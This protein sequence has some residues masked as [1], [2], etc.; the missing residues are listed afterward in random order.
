MRVIGPCALTILRKEDHVLFLFSDNHYQ[1]LS[2]PEPE[3]ITIPKFCNLIR[4]E[5][6]EDA[7][8]YIEAVPAP[9]PDDVRMMGQTQIQVPQTINANAARDWIPWCIFGVVVEGLVIESSRS[10]EEKYAYF[11]DVFLPK[12]LAHPEIYIAPVPTQ[13]IDFDMG[14]LRPHILPFQKLISENHKVLNWILEAAHYLRS[15]TDTEVA[16]EVTNAIH[17]IQTSRMTVTHPQ[18]GSKFAFVY[19]SLLQSSS[20]DD[21]IL[22]IMLQYY[23]R[24]TDGYVIGSIQQPRVYKGTKRFDVIYLGHAHI[25]A[26]AQYLIE[27]KGWR[28]VHTHTSPQRGMDEYIETPWGDDLQALLT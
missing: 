14:Y 2:E 17:A 15:I 1:E 27:T 9:D 4:T 8:V 6:D 5:L 19:G 10:V 13:T 18:A 20:R 24:F 28:S 3:D 7:A 25:E 23:A 12:L 21:G 16:T 11:R 22:F 26:I